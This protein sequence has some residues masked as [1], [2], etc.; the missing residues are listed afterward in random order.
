MHRENYTMKK[1][2]IRRA[3]TQHEGYGRTGQV[4]IFKTENPLYTNTF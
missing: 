4:L 3:L 2:S 1:K